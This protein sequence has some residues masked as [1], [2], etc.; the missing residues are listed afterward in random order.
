M[1][2]FE[3]EFQISGPEELIQDARDVLAAMAGEAGYETFEDTAE[4][5]KGYVQQDLYAEDAVAAVIA[6]FPFEDITV[7]YVTR[8]AEY[9]DWNEQWENEGF[10]PIFITRECVVHDGRHLPEKPCKT[11]VEID[12]KLAFGTG[13]HETTR[14]VAQQLILSDPYGK[15][16]LDC[17]CGT[18]IL[19]IIALKLGASHVVGYDIDEWSAD[20]AR[21]NAVING[22]GDDYDARLGDAGIVEAESQQF[23]IILANINRNILLAD[24]PRWR[25]LMSP[26]GTLIL[27]GFYASDVEALTTKAAELGLKVQ[28]HHEDGDWQCLVFKVR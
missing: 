20:N 28:A 27:S 8:E 1:K 9:R 15:N 5:I 18:G 26:S 12:A 4:G 22:V 25:P 24:M 16:V 13:T 2:Y 14:M 6:D 10:E 21:H 17:G 3:T 11:M 7:S 23:D 19:G